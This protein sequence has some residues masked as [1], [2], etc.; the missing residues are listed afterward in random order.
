MG[1]NLGQDAAP[2]REDSN[3]GRGTEGKRKKRGFCFIPFGALLR[4]KVPLLD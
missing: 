3:G 1:L 2:K 4:S